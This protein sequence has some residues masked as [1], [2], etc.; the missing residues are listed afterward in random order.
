MRRRSMLLFS[1]LILAGCGLFTPTVS[2]PPPYPQYTPTSGAANRAPRN[3]QWWPRDT[4]TTTAARSG[5][6]R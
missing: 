3:K 6:G 4:A 5:A 1:V 2:S